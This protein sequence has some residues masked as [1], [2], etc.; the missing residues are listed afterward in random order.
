[1]HSL[2]NIEPYE[3]VNASY[4]AAALENNQLCIANPQFTLDID[5]AN[6]SISKI[7]NYDAET[8]ICY[9]GGIF[10]RYKND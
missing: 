9:H 4:D 5:N 10:K 3:I 8:Y 2:Q 6:K 7:L 1:M